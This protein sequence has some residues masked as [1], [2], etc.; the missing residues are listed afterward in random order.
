MAKTKQTKNGTVEKKLIGLA[1]LVVTAAQHV[2]DPTMAIP[3]RALS[4]VTYNGRKGLIEMG[5]KNRH[6]H[7]S[8]WAWPRSSCRPC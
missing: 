5:N 6:V 3:I 4:N 7:S 1:D 2:K 8:T